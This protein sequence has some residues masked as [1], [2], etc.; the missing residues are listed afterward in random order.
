MEKKNVDS[1]FNLGRYWLHIYGG[2]WVKK[3]EG[4]E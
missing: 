3:G 4:L 2:L 1:I